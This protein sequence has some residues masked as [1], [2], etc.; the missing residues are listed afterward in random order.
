MSVPN[1]IKTMRDRGLPPQ[2][3]Q[4]NPF[5]EAQRK[6]DDLRA[7]AETVLQLS[8]ETNDA[9]RT[10]VAQVE[11]LQREN[12]RLAAQVTQL[13]RENRIVNAYGQNI[14]SRMAVIKEGIEAAERES[15][16][17]ANHRV[18]T[19]PVDTAEEKAEV[20]HIVDAIARVQ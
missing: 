18:T 13:S 16:E 15:L 11:S 10:L 8:H 19:R 4:E 2:P 1:F 6:W 20:S 9:N 7:Y 12:D 5:D 3:P 14:R 17:Y